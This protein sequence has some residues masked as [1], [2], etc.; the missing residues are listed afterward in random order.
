[1]TCRVLRKNKCYLLQSEF[2]IATFSSVGDYYTCVLH[3]FYYLKTYT[4]IFYTHTPLSGQLIQES[5]VFGLETTALVSER[6]E[7]KVYYHSPSAM[8]C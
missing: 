8:K 6:T 7:P 2:K 4:H 5:R 3:A 1:M